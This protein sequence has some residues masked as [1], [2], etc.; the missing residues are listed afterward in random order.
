QGAA[1]LIGAPASRASVAVLGTRIGPASVSLGDAVRVDVTLRNGGAEPVGT[2]GP[3]PGAVYGARDTF[4]SLG[5]PGQS[6]RVRIGVEVDG[7]G[8]LD[9][10]FRWGLGGELEPQEV[11]TVS[12]LVRFDK[13]GPHRLWVGLVQEDVGWLQDNLGQTPIT[14]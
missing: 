12:G 8:T 9:H 6:G 3:D 11:R 2:Q 14:V 10:R 1:T 4:T 5:S 13:P 7:D